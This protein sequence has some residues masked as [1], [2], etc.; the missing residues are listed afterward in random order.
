MFFINNIIKPCCFAGKCHTQIL[1]RFLLMRAF[2]LLYYSLYQTQADSFFFFFIVYIPSTRLPF[3]VLITAIF[4]DLLISL[5]ICLSDSKF[6]FC[7]IGV[8][9]HFVGVIFRTTSNKLLYD[10][11][12]LFNNFAKIVT[13]FDEI[14]SICFML[15]LG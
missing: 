5:T 3:D 2:C 15:N 4:G 13:Q 10:V 11:A 8:I 14:F 1:R 12:M 7:A 6:S 9:C